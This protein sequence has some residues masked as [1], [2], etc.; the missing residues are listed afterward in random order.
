MAKVIR[1]AA[2]GGV[3]AGSIELQ[4]TGKDA[5]ARA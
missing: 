5:P 3:I 1:A 4:L 2:Q